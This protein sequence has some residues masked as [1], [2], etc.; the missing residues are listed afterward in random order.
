MKLNKFF[1]VDA[2]TCLPLQPAFS[3]PI[4]G[5]AVQIVDTGGGTRKVLLAKMSSSMQVLANQ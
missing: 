1:I 2:M 5:V 3:A 4:E